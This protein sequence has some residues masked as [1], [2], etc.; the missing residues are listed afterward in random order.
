[1]YIKL[2]YLVQCHQLTWISNREYSKSNV[3]NRPS[4]KNPHPLVSLKINCKK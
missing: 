2:S 3:E 1:M 4:G